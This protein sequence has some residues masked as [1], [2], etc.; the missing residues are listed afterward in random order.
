MQAQIGFRSPTPQSMYSEVAQRYDL[1]HSILTFGLAR[2][3][4]HKAARQLELPPKGRIL[5]LA[6]GTASLALAIA[7]VAPQDSVIIGGDINEQM[8]AVARKRLQKSRSQTAIELKNFSAEALPF[9]DCLFDAVTMA[10]AL[11]D[12][13]NRQVCLQEIFRVLKPDGQILIL[14]L[15]LPDA[16]WMLSLYRIFLWFLP[17]IS[18]LFSEGN[19]SNL[20]EEI[21]AYQGRL[22]REELI[23][24]TGF[25]QYQAHSLSGGLVTIHLARKPK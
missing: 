20:S 14:D 18:H 17:R 1:L 12:L 25:T 21:L 24:N 10:F 19:S 23:K 22:A 8:L 16:P 13:K 5:D 3:W 15:S 7:T 11:D 9:H 6:T 2:Q 4:H